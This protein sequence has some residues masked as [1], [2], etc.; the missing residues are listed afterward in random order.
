MI[1]YVQENNI[2]EIFSWIQL[3]VLSKENKI[4]KNTKKEKKRRNVSFSLYGRT[5]NY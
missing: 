5:V 4:R 3:Y 2:I 1:I